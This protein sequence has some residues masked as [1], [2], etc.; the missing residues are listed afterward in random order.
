MNE[1][2]SDWIEYVDNKAA[3]LNA[4]SGKSPGLNRLRLAQVVIGQT[5]DFL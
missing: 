2:K 3:L 4:F 5:G 1:E